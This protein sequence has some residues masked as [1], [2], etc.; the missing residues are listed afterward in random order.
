MEV[1]F[2][3]EKRGNHAPSTRIYAPTHKS[4]VELKVMSEEGT[5]VRPQPK[6]EEAEKARAQAAAPKVDR[7]VILSRLLILL[8]VFVIAATAI[9]AIDGNA[10]VA[11]IYTEIYE[12]QD[13]IASYENQI[14]LLQKQQSSLNDYATI[15]QANQEAGRT[16]NWELGD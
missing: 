11:K 10:K 13:E 12:L 3:T 8:T 15:N 9:L 1:S 5:A 14:S 7:A 4:E 16:M 6:A 2:D